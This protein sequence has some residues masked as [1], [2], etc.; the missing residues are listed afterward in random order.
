MYEVIASYSNCTGI[1]KQTKNKLGAPQ[2]R[3]LD[4]CL[5]L[6]DNT[7]SELKAVMSDLR[8]EKSSPAKHYNH[9]RT[10][11]SAAMTNQYT[12][13]EGFDS[14]NEGKALKNE[15]ESRLRTTCKHVSN[16]LAMLKKIPGVV[17]EYGPMKQGFPTWV[18]SKARK[19]LQTSS[20]NQ[21]KYNLVVAKDGTGNFTTITDAVAAAPNSSATR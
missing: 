15:M 16:A 13:L 18:G 2:Q 10:L 6:F 1:K 9:L 7:I 21:T 3:A 19:L 5:E 4:D 20:A 17:D 11:L 8:S 14:S 12:C